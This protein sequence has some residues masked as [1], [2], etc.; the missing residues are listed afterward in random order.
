M[1]ALAADLGLAWR[2]LYFCTRFAEKF[3]DLNAFLGCHKSGQKL[4]WLAVSHTLLV[5][6]R[7]SPAGENANHNIL[8]APEYIA[9]GSNHHVH[10]TPVTYAK[11]HASIL[12]L[13]VNDTEHRL[14]IKAR[15]P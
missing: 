15:K 1:K 7:R 3:P 10:S 6:S 11:C 2:D 13:H 9:T 14:L 5:Q 12:V 8:E 4:T